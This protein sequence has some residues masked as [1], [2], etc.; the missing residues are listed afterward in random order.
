LILVPGIEFF[1]GSEKKILSFIMGSDLNHRRCI[2][3]LFGSKKGGQSGSGHPKIFDAI[4][5]NQLQES[6]IIS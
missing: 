3:D 2:D 6:P 5:T 4:R 1:N